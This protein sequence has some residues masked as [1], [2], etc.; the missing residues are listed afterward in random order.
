MNKAQNASIDATNVN[1]AS[2]NHAEAFRALD[3]L[4]VSIHEFS[5]TKTRCPEGE[6]YYDRTK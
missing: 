3:N 4:S 1:M 2:G 6:G 5:L